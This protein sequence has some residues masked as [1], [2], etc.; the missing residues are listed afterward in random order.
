MTTQDDIETARA[1][2][3]IAEGNRIQAIRLLRDE[4]GWTLRVAKHITDLIE[5]SE[6]RSLLYGAS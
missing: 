6:I 3:L 5:D 1:A 2:L 4:C